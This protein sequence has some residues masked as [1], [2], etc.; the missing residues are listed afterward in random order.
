MEAV[1][2]SAL[3][4]RHKSQATPTAIKIVKQLLLWLLG[5]VFCVFL[6]IFF[7]G[8]EPS[9]ALRAFYCM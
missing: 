8:T 4:S 2:T 9:L 7:T 6:F 1:E 3:T 5:R